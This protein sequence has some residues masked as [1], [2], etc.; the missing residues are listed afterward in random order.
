MTHVCTDAT[1]VYTS[2]EGVYACVVCDREHRVGRDIQRCH[3][4]CKLFPV[5][6]L[7]KKSNQDGGGRFC[8]D[9]CEQ[10]FREVVDAERRETIAEH[11]AAQTYQHDH[12]HR[13]GQ[14]RHLTCHCGRE[15]TTQ[16][17]WRK[18]CSTRCCKH[19]A[20]RAL[21]ARRKQKQEEQ[22]A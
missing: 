2:T 18:H 3:G 10:T 14:V 16:D 6:L 22:T 15:F 17:P 12:P 4:C 13:I 8:S 21:R 19:A 7:R 1:L 5:K 11:D 9:A 20:A